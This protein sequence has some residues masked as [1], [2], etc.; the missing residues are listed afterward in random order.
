MPLISL[1][2]TNLQITRSTFN[3]RSTKFGMKLNSWWRKCRMISRMNLRKS[4]RSVLRSNSRKWPRSRWCSRNA[5]L[6]RSQRGTRS[7]LKSRRTWRSWSSR[8]SPMPSVE[9]R[10]PKLSCKLRSRTNWKRSRTP[11]RMRGHRAPAPALERAWMITWH[12][13]KQGLEELLPP[14]TVLEAKMI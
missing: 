3:K 11:F 6:S 7:W 4:L 8:G 13:S 1:T 2:R 9:C 12:L 14:W 5:N 10:R